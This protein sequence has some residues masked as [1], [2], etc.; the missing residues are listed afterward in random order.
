[1]KGDVMEKIMQATGRTP[2]H[3]NCPICR[4]QCKIPCL[5]T[6]KDIK[7]LI[8]K[9]YKNSLLPSLWMVGVMLGELSFPIPMV[10]AIRTDEGWCVFHIAGLCK[11][12]DLGLKPTE[13]RLS[14]HTIL[15]ENF[16]FR[17][18]LAYHVAKE[19]LSPENG[20]LVEE[21]FSLYV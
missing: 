5:G 16:V 2:S 3:C 9:G 17:K 4:N 8:D 14:H 15:P 21:I 13:G 6:P 10:Q 7:R 19:W 1:M 11:L 20:R 12:H 18:G